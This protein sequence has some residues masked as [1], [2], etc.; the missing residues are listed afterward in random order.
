MITGMIRTFS[1]ADLPALTQL[2]NQHWTQLPTHVPIENATLEQAVLSRLFFEPDHLLVHEA[3]GQ[4]N[5]WCQFALP[6]RE[7]PHQTAQILTL[8]WAESQAGLTLLGEV[9]TRCEDLGVRGVDV[10]VSQDGWFGY[11][12]LAPLGYGVGVPDFDVHNSQLLIQQGFEVKRT[13]CRWRASTMGYR[14]PVNR[15]VM[16]LRRSTTV[17]VDSALLNDCRQAQAYSHFDVCRYQLIDRGRNTLASLHALKS[18]PEAEVMSPSHAII[19]LG[20]CDDL[21]A[22]EAFLVSNT[23]MELQTQ[24]INSVEI[25]VA[26][27][28]ATLQQ[29]LQRL[30]FQLDGRGSIWNKTR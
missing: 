10:G 18:D 5:A 27:Q 8:C 7:S 19:D 16:Q 17:E 20:K 1:N 15:D 25:V 21:G 23:V 30:N 3:D 26:E 11:A 9:L 29:Q 28:N 2:W 12:G 24:Q 22:P 14:L 4:I 6:P 13:Y